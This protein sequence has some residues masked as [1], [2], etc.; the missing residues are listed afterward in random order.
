MDVRGRIT[1]VSPKEKC[2]IWKIF[3]DRSSVGFNAQQK[4]GQV[5][6]GET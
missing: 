5:Q 3:I 1:D 2:T 4:E 6:Q